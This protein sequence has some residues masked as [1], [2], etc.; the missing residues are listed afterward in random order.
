[1]ARHHRD[2]YFGIPFSNGYISKQ[3]NGVPSMTPASN[4]DEFFRDSGDYIGQPV[5]DSDFR[6]EKCDKSKID[7]LSGY[8]DLGG[9][10][11]VNVVNHPLGKYESG[12]DY[13]KLSSGAPSYSALATTA[14]ARTNPS[15]PEF[16]AGELIQGIA[17]VPRMIKEIGDHL[18]KGSINPRG[19][20]GQYLA[21]NFGWLPLF[22]DM[23]KMLDVHR[24][25]DRRNAELKRLFSNQGLRRRV[26]LGSYTN[27]ETTTQFVSSGTNGTLTCKRSIRA[28]SR[29]WATCRWKPALHP[30][31]YPSDSQRLALA[32]RIVIGATASG[33]FASSWDLIPWTWLLGW[34]VNVR[35]FV[36]AHGNTI[37]CTH[38]DVNVMDTH[39]QTQEFRVLSR[40]SWLHGGD[41]VI[42][43]ERLIRS[44][45]SKPALNAYIPHLSGKR[46]S[47][48]G[49]L[50]VQRFRR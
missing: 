29:I 14:L 6:L 44:I 4:F 40:S 25:I 28:Q 18:R 32:K 9:G 31:Q 11:F 2:R 38:D 12:Y 5:V 19:I 10:N 49:A 45:R 30:A 42:E 36:L 50:T 1:M 41:G 39:Y 46:L 43:H 15:R 3:V 20:A 7:R 37:P 26:S 13:V 24:Y 35:D 8:N 22:D 33:A 16:V 47:I 34:S 48:L 17:S 23:G 27:T 21:A